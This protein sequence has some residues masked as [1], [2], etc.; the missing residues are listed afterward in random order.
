[1][2]EPTIQGPKLVLL[3]RDTD[4]TWM[5]YNH[6]HPQV[7]IGYILLEKP[8]S[9]WL[10]I[11]N[12]AKRVGWMKALGQVFFICC[13]SPLLNFL[14]RTQ[15]KALYAQF[16]LNSNKPANKKL[17]LVPSVNSEECQA[18]LKKI[19]PDLVLVNGTRIISNQT[20]QSVTAP[21][22]NIHDGITPAFRGV[23]GGY[24]ALAS[25]QPE[26]FGTTIHFVDKGV[27]TGGIIEQIFLQPSKNDNFATYPI[28][29]HA[30]ALPVLKQVLERILSGETI[31]TRQPVCEN[32]PIHFHPTIWEW[33]R[34]RKRTLGLIFLFQT[35]AHFS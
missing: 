10:L 24:W 1:M 11:R 14:S 8:I 23:H 26:L 5:I 3:A 31:T 4:S 16:H 20:L 7:P 22:V 25:G 34:N 21:F 13:I 9:R 29:Q 35:L 30:A 28:L 19:N 18:I 12:R 15:K 6:I 32:S 2:N 17:I 33:M 27:D